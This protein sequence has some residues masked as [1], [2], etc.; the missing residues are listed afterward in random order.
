LAEVRFFIY[1]SHKQDKITLALV[2]LFSIPDLT[3]LSLSVST[4]WSYQYQDD[5]ALKFINVK[6]IQAVISMVP[7]TPVIGGQPA[8]RCF[9]LVEKPGLDVALMSGAEEE[10]L[11]EE[12]QA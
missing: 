12:V 5:L 2:S 11:G 4:L 9:F 1:I 10:M 7:H 3:L 8:A 6:N